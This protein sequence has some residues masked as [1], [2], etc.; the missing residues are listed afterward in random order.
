MPANPNWA[1]WVFASVA[2][3][4][5]QVA[6]SQQLPVL[7]EGLDDRTT[8]F[9]EAT[10][11][12]EI[13]VTGPFTKELSH[14][15]FQIEVVVNVLFLSRYEEQKN[16]YAIIQKMG[17]FHE[18]MDGAIAVYKYGTGPE[19]DEHA[20]VGCLSPVQGRSDAIRVMHFG[21]I[22]PTDRIKQSMVDARYRM[23]I[24]TNQ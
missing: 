10:D 16:Q 13:R 22:T 7:V 15:Y 5:R 2:T 21:Q 4:L 6:Q 17:V 14:N 1:R 3:F 12:C 9:M 23:E 8:E 18:A 20:L 11:R 24:S 19:D